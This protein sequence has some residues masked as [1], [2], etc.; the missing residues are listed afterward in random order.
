MI[1][2]ELH[3]PTR[4]MNFDGV[5]GPTHNYAGLSFGNVASESNTG[6]AS[7]P[8]A[9]ALQGLAKMRRLMELGLPQGVLP[10]QE[11]PHLPTLRALGFSGSDAEVIAAAAKADP[12]LL[13]QV[14][15]ASCMWTANAATVGPSVD[16]ADGRVHFTPAN[17][18]SMAHR[19][20]EGPQTQRTLRAIFADERRFAVH[21][22]LPA[23]DAFGDEGAANHTRLFDDR[24][25]AQPGAGV[26]L[27]VYGVHHADRGSARPGKFPARQTL[28]ASRAVARLHGLDPARCVF[29]LQNPGVIDQGV[30]HND[31]IAVGNGRVLFYHE[32]AFADEAGVLARLRA[33]V[34]EAFTPV[35]VRTV[36]VPVDVCVRTYLFNSQLVTLTDGSMALISPTESRDEARVRG[37]IDAVLADPANPIRA[38]HF[39]D[40]RESMRNGGGPACLRLRVPLTAADLAGVSPGCVC[41]PAKLGELEAWVTRHYRETLTPKDL[42]DPQLLRESRGALDELTRILGLGALYEFQRG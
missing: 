27:F 30:F 15:S 23:A 41:T 26:H 19:F 36:D 11:R 4:E 13:A 24:D 40:L 35:K 20:I 12:V 42:A 1:Q 25:G 18:R 28:E 33:L 29:A 22:P 16:T 3:I 5:V 32:Q 7:R 21:P 38:V 2:S 37:V 31:V 9:A 39:M 6:S 17:L 14:S 10:P 34:G 8:R